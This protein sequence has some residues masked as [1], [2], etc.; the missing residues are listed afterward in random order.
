MKL[1]DQ[2]QKLTHSQSVVNSRSAQGF[3]SLGL[4]GKNN[5]NQR[6]EDPQLADLLQPSTS[7]ERKGGKHAIEEKS[8][9]EE[10]VDDEEAGEEEVDEQRSQDLGAN[11]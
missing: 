1:K 6:N 4:M 3:G 7:A 2:R 8:E 9:K 10:E 5:R 11:D